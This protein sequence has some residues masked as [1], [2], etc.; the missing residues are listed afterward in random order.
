MHVHRVGGIGGSER[1][2]LT[3]LPALAERGV[4]VSFLGLDDTSRAPDPFY[5]ALTVPYERLPAPRDLDVRL[6]LAVRRAIRQA[7][8]VHTH[9]VH[10]D[11][12]GALGCPATRVDEAQRRPVSRRGVPL[13][14]ARARPAGREDHCDHE[15]ARALPDRACRPSRREGGGRSLRPRRPACAVGGERAGPGGGRCASASRDLAPRAA[16]GPRRRGASVAAHPRESSQGRARRA[17]RRAA[18]SRAVGACAGARGAGAPARPRARRRGL[19]AACRAP[20]PSCAL[21]GI[22]SRTPRGDARLEA[23]R[24]D[25]CQLDPRDRVGRR[26]GLARRP[27]R[28]GRTCE[29]GE[30]RARR[31]RRVRRARARTRQSRSSAS[32]R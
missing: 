15:R 32:R 19:A 8:L 25:E 26:D 27:R 3:L 7:D 30:P 22:R 28:S 11:V 9:L 12:Y 17:G 6:A 14:R 1:H 18:A 29:S 2:L 13:R 20:R 10:A 23:R 5:E 4:D 21:G 31:T 24:R 16:E